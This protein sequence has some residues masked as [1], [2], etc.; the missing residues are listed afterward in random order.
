MGFFDSFKKKEPEPPKRVLKRSYA[1]AAVSRL[2]ADFTT[3][4][5]SPDAELKN[6][7]KILRSRSRELARNNEYARQY[8]NLMKK[9][10]VGRKGFTLQVKALN[11][12]GDLDMSGNDEIEKSFATW[13][14]LGNCTV[15]GKMTWVDVQKMVM[16]TLIRDGEAFIVKHYSSSFKHNFALQ[17]I[18]PD[19][20]DETYTV[21]SKNGSNEIRMGVELDKYKRPVAYHVLSNHPGDLEYV[22]IT[23]SRKYIRLPADRVYHVYQQMRPGQTRGEPWMAPAMS[24]IKQL[25]GF[26]EAAVINARI[27]ASK[28]GFFTSPAGDG[29]VADEMDG[30]TP[31]MTA[32]PGTFHSLPDGVNFTAFDPQFPSSDFDPFHKSVLKGISSALGVSYTAL[33]NDLEATSYSSIRQGALEERDTYSDHQ[34]FIIDHFVRPVYED[35]LKTVMGMG[36]LS[37]PLAT[38]DKFSQA[39]EFRGRAW[40]WVDPLKEMNAS[41]AGLKSGVLSLQDVAAQYGKDVEELLSQIKKDKEL[42][43]QFGISYAFE[44]YGADH[45]PVTPDGYDT[46]GEEP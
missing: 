6:A 45:T 4:S 18:E 33:A 28:M 24:A 44:P 21:P 11:S 25:D 2:F 20:I 39:S 22:S 1:G 17:F 15:D 5:K 7:L 41:I 26:R 9:N 3:D 40:S 46:T 29:F 10:V 31:I 12:V 42:M 13:G 43:T 36:Q 19:Q 27:G 16:E 34:G 23:N 8:L 14:K 35:W 32:D 38:F 37:L 30:H